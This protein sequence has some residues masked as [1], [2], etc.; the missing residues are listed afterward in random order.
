MISG[1]NEQATSDNLTPPALPG[2]SSPGAEFRSIVVYSLVAGACPL[3]PVPLL[4]D[5]ILDRV[6]RRLIARLASSRSV[7]L[8]TV[9]LQALADRDPTDWSAEGLARGCLRRLFVAPVKFVYKR[10][11]RKLFR[12]ILF[13][14][15]IKDAVD[16]VSVTFHHAWLLR[17]ALDRSRS[18][19]TVSAARALRAEVDHV[20]KELDPRPVESA[21][22]SAIRH[23]RRLF[24]RLAR[25]LA[26]LVRRRGDR[27]IDEAVGRTN[28]EASGLIDE[29]IANLGRETTYLQ[30]LERRLDER[31]AQ[32]SVPF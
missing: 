31:L 10:I 25:L 3:I 24:R 7:D 22:R 1:V 19:K 27:G 18:P 12:K 32:S 9:R 21:V 14:L 5:W 28:S 26:T 4:D 15:S 23:S 11:I 16:E 20:C 2:P 8:G 29:L 6:R 30:A 13:V 17:H